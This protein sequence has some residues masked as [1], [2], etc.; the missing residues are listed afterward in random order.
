[1]S[2]MTKSRAGRIFGRVKEIWDELDYAQRRTLE[3]RTGIPL[4][5]QANPDITASVSDLE[6]LYALEED[7]DRLSD[8]HALPDRI[9]PSVDRRSR[10]AGSRER[11]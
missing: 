4:T 7:H 3:I 8:R 2:I 10:Q 6:S 11:V 1:M 9:R 5:Q